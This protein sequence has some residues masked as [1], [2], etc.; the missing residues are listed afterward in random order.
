M[1]CL[2]VISES[3]IFQVERELH[4]QEVIRERERRISEEKKREEERE[5]AREKERERTRKERAA[6]HL[7]EQQQLGTLRKQKLHAVSITPQ[8]AKFSEMAL[9]L[10]SSN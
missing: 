10:I 2:F 1:T 9:E 7:R 3:N 8:V 6:L 4:R 5:K